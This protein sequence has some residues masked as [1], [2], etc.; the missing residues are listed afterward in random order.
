MQLNPASLPAAK[1]FT[2]AEVALGE[3]DAALATWQTWTN[4]HPSDANAIMLLGTLEDA[5]GDDPKAEADYKKALQLDPNNGSASNNLAYMMVEDG[6]NMDVALSLAQTARRLLP[7]RPE[8]ADTLAWV[9][10]HKEDYRA[11]RDLL[12]E[13]LKTFPDDASINLHLGMTDAML[14]DK[15]DAQVH[16]KKAISIAPNS[17]TGKVA[18]DE[19]AKLGQ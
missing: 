16:L 19:L 1:G 3:I 6:E 2:Q 10:Y 8:P 5:K 15:S 7:D 18:A 13:A 12:E 11:A 9:Y 17:K 14:N 4:A